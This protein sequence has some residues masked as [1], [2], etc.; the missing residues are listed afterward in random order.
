[1]YRLK[2][3]LQKYWCL[4]QYFPKLSHLATLY[5]VL[6]VTSFYKSTSWDF[7]GGSMDK[8]PP[9]NEEDMGVITGLGT[10]YIPRSN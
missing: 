7:P 5:H 9:A 10:S 8:N 3:V 1:M 2:E 6:S 4:E